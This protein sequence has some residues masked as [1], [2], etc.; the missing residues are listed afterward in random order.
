MIWAASCTASPG[1]SC[2][3]DKTNLADARS[4]C[5]DADMRLCALHELRKRDCK[6][7]TCGSN[8]DKQR[9]WTSTECGNPLHGSVLV[10]K[11]KGGKR[12]QKCTLPKTPHKIRCCADDEDRRLSPLSMDMGRVNLSTHTIAANEGEDDE[13]DE[14]E[15]EEEVSDRRLEF[16]SPILV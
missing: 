16:A 6:G 3:K 2:Q 1:G 7:Q 15:E 5:E 12:S 14:E 11:A 4:I 13:E 10:S 8:N 9:V